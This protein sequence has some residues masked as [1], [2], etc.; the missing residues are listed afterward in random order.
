LYCIPYDTTENKLHYNAQISE[1]DLK[2]FAEVQTGLGWCG[3]HYTCPQIA[4]LKLPA[5]CL[6]ICPFLSRHEVA[7]NPAVSRHAK[8]KFCAFDVFFFISDWIQV[9]R[10]RC[11][12]F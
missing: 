6:S 12:D 8:I 11:A 3:G 1:L 9:F 5:V 4:T 7:H 10:I 2:S